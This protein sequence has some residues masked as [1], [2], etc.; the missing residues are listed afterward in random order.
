MTHSYTYYAF[1]NYFFP[2]VKV[3]FPRPVDFKVIKR[4]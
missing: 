1:P 2:P 4:S 3:H